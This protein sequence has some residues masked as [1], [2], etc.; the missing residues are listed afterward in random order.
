[1]APIALA[2]GGVATAA[3]IAA[4]APA[5]PGAPVPGRYAATLCVA[6]SGA[7][8]PGCGAAE[9]DL[10]SRDRAQLSVADIVYRLQLRPTGV[11]VTTMHG[12][13]QV[14]AFSAPYEWSGRVLRFSDADKGVRYEVRLGDSLGGRAPGGR[15]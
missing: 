13:I 11:D 3:A 5:T 15:R 7:A 12:Q 2:L 10:R 9:F 6:T 4:S 1:M 8:T 14:D